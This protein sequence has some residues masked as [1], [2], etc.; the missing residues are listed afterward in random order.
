MF[1]ITVKI[2]WNRRLY[3]LF[4]IIL[5]YCKLF[6]DYLFWIIRGIFETWIIW[7]YLSL[8]YLYIIRNMDYLRIF[9]E[10]IIWEHLF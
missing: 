2:I 9:E 8:D 7:D 1:H 10:W 3:E 6:V 5:D 4:E